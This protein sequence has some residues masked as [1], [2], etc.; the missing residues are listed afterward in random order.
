MEVV[1]REEADERVKAAAQLV[2]WIEDVAA[3]EWDRVPPSVELPEPLEQRLREVDAFHDQPLVGERERVPPHPTTDVEHALAGSETRE[4]DEL[5]DLTSNVVRVGWPHRVFPRAL[6]VLDLRAVVAR[7]CVPLEFAHRL[8]VCL[9]HE[10]AQC[11]RRC[12]AAGFVS[13]PPR[14]RA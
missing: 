6:E 9:P 8:S 10:S 14:T 4:G 12:G 13:S 2:G 11:A 7:K 3:V 5:V 1:E